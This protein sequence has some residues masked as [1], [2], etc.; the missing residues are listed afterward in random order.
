[1]KK[2]LILNILFILLINMNTTI[3]KDLD[4]LSVEYIKI[5]LEIG[6]KDK[7]FVDA[8]YGPEEYKPTGSSADIFLKKEYIERIDKLQSEIYDISLLTSDYIVANRANWMFDQL[9]A[10][11][12]RVKIF[13]GETTDF[14]NESLELFGVIAPN[15]EK[16]YFDD[17]LNELENLVPGDGNLNQRINDVSKKFVI[18]EDKLDIVFKAA[19]EEARKRTKTHYQLPD[20][21][22]F[23]LEYVKGTSWSG[24]NWY[25]GDYNS[26]IQINTDLPIFIDRAIDLAC[27]EGYPG[28]HIY[29][30]LLEKKLYKEQNLQEI[31]LYPLFSPQSLIAEGTANYGIEVAFPGNE[32]VEFTKNV[33]LPLAGLDTNGIDL[34]FR[35][36]EIKGKLN[37][38]RNEVGRG[39]LNRTMSNDDAIQWL[40]K[41]N[42]MSREGAEKSIKFMIKY[43]T[44]IINYNYGLELVRNYIESQGGTANNPQKRWELFSYLL[45]NQ[46]RIKDLLNVK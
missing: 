24:Y 5:A 3:S 39:L 41:Y 6:E 23:T 32:K 42:L 18:P 34:F 44:Y 11:K 10:F 46:I 14:D 35:I 36:N 17:L 19:I 15:Y 29:N 28:H 20:N 1:M 12:R 8:Y 31:T 38:A 22:K 13:S 33:L 26:L 2:L 7:D 9:T 30:L 40:I 37:F 4:Q 16:E 27:H 25:K 45:S 21:E 43:R